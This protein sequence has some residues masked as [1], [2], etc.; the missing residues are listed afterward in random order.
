MTNSKNNYMRREILR[1]IEVAAVILTLIV[2][3]WQVRSTNET[4]QRQ[5]KLIIEQN[6][7][8]SKQNNALLSDLTLKGQT[9]FHGHTNRIN[10]LLL[11]KKELRSVV[12]GCSVFAGRVSGVA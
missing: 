7:T 8:I 10:N 1:F 4:S 3:Y 2:L 6:D 11:D 5:L 12:Q 9:A